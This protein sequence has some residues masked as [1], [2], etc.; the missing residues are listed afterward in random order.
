MKKTVKQQVEFYLLQM[1]KAL[2]EIKRQVEVYEQNLKS[3]KV[4]KPY[5]LITPVR[6]V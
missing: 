4:V 3:G 6:N 1:E 2:P 5:S